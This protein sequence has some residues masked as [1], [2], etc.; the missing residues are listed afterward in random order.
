MLNKLP[1]W[2]AH[3]VTLGSGP[4]A[5]QQ[6]EAV[7][8]RMHVSGANF[9]I[10]LAMPKSPP[11][12]LDGLNKS[13]DALVIHLT[14]SELLVTFEDALEMLKVAETLRSSV[15]STHWVSKDGKNRNPLVVYVVPKPE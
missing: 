9:D 8:H 11:Q 13:P 10:L 1:M 12:W 14:G 4:L 3:F 2:I 5:A 7:L 6:Q 15:S